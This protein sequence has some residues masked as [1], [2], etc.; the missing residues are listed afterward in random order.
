MTIALLLMLKQVYGINKRYDDKPEELAANATAKGKAPFKHWVN[1]Y[2]DARSSILLSMEGRIKA[3]DMVF[4]N[5]KMLWDKLP[6]A[7]LSTLK[8]NIIDIRED[9]WSIKLKGFGD[10]YNFTAQIDRKVNDYNLC[11]GPIPPSTTDT[12]AASMNA[13]KTIT[14]LSE[15]DLI[16]NPLS[17]M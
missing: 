3:A 4:D 2:G 16:F 13:V 8:F 9:S 14:N 10:F 15:Q 5:A 11:P 1:C 7:Y 12:D 17:A 6:L